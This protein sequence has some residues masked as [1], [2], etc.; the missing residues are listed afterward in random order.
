M[1]KAA[2]LLV[3]FPA[4]RFNFKMSLHLETCQ[5]SREMMRI[6]IESMGSYPI[7]VST[8]LRHT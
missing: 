2:K 8:T 3:N 6:Q 1:V 7:L 4:N 5:I